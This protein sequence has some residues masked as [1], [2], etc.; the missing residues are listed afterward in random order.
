MSA[1]QA[2]RSRPGMT[3]LAAAEY[4]GKGSLELHDPTSQD[5][6]KNRQTASAS[7]LLSAVPHGGRIVFSDGDGNLRWMER[8]GSTLV[9]KYNINS[10]QDEPSTGE[11]MS[12]GIFSTSGSEMPGQ[13]DIVQKML[14]LRAAAGSDPSDRSDLPS[15]SLLLWSGDGRLGCL[16]FGGQNPLTP[17]DDWHDAL[18]A[19]GLSAEEKAKEDAARQ[20]EM[21]MRRA[22]ERNADEVRFVRGLGM[23]AF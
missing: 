16:N 23:A 14:P 17:D 22:L 6:Y 19:Q 7:K 5:S 3:L 12:N 10:G 1:L 20:Y 18:E 21:T 11:I 9:R 13:G 4:K 8:D 15:E 2:A